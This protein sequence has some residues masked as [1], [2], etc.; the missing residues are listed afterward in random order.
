LAPQTW[1]YDGSV[2]RK[3]FSIPIL[4]RPA[5]QRVVLTC[6]VPSLDQSLRALH[7]DEVMVEHVYDY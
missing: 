2:A 6:G 4:T 5:W 1:H 7:S 3:V